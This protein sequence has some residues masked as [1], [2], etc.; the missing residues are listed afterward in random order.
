MGRKIHPRC[1]AFR[2]MKLEFK[3]FGG[4]SIIHTKRPYMTNNTQS[5]QSLDTQLDLSEHTSSPRTR[6]ETVTRVSAYLPVRL[7]ETSKKQRL[8]KDSKSQ[9]PKVLEWNGAQYGTLGV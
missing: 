7:C 8:M 9:N 3:T 6:A 2:Q 4:T 1:N 5:D